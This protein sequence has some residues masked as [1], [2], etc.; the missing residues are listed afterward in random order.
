MLFTTETQMKQSKNWVMF[1]A[2][3]AENIQNLPPPAGELFLLFGLS[4]KS[5]KVSLSAAFASL[6]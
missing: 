2:E 4:A 5:K 3:T 1:S 6:R